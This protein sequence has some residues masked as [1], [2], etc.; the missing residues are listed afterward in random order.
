[1]Y[2][3]KETKNNSNN[4]NN[5]NNSFIDLFMYSKERKPKMTLII[6]MCY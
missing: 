5:N 4:N 1:M 3:K 6:I 2:G